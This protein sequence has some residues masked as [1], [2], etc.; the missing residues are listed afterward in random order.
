MQPKYSMMI[1]WS[2]EDQLYLVHLP[3]FPWQHFVTH[4]TTYEEAA[5]N[6]QEALEGL[7]E[8]LQDAGQPLPS[9]I[10]APQVA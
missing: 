9:Y 1:Q 5:K 3:E 8:V 10:A 4:G 6:G 7:I 2:E